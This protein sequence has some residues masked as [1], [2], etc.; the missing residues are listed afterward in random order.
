MRGATS[1]CVPSSPFSVATPSPTRSPPRWRD[2]FRCPPADALV[3]ATLPAF[4][5]YTVAILWAFAAR[6][7]WRVCCGALLALPLA[8]IGF[9]PQLL[10]R[11]G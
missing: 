4:L 8:V 10:E 2:D 6:D 3:V 9:W 5:V 11:I 7:L 1:P